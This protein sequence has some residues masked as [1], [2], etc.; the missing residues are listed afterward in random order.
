MC[1]SKL[2][3]NSQ[4]IQRAQENYNDDDEY[5]YLCG[6]SNLDEFGELS[7]SQYHL[8]SIECDALREN[9]KGHIESEGG[10]NK[11]F[12]G[13]W[14]IVK[15]KDLKPTVQHYKTGQELEV[16]IS[17]I[18]DSRR[19]YVQP[20]SVLDKIKFVDTKIHRFVTKYLESIKFDKDELRRTISHQE[21][22]AKFD[23]VLALSRANK[24]KRAILLE[25]VTSSQFDEFEDFEQIVIRDMKKI[26]E[27]KVYFTFFLIDSGKEETIVRSIN[28]E[29][30]FILPLTGHIMHGSFCLKCTINEGNIRVKGKHGV[31]HVENRLEFERKFK[32]VLLNKTVVLK[33]SSITHSINDIEAMVDL[34]FKPNDGEMLIEQLNATI[35][36]DDTNS[37]YNSNISLMSKDLKVNCGSYIVRLIMVEKR[38]QVLFILELTYFYV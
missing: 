16:R 28:E 1:T 27:E 8:N 37:I 32:E 9:L 34:Y 11:L 29:S 33:I 31:S 24:W 3:D 4:D 5:K 2:N 30:L 26:K 7:A 15:R 20:V 17:F 19:F 10:R 22:I 12:N 25:K 13:K 21:N 35:E 38:E 36:L 14:K 6:E 18:D 23:V